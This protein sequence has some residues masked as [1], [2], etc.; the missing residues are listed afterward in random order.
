MN[1]TSKTLNIRGA[2]STVVHAIDTDNERGITLCGSWTGA[3]SV[4]VYKPL[5]CAACM[6]IRIDRIVK[7]REALL[8]SIE[9]IDA[10]CADIVLSTEES[11][12]LDKLVA[13]ADQFIDDYKELVA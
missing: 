10:M 6:K 8:P 13:T 5:N 12:E 3:K 9:L 2:D 11:A 7:A 1:T 4:S